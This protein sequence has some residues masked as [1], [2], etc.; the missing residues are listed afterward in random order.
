[1]EDQ[2]TDLERRLIALGYGKLEARYANY[3][4]KE[5]KRWL[6]ATWHQ[7]AVVREA[8]MLD[9][10]ITVLGT[11]RDA[12]G[13][14]DE[15]VGRLKRRLE[16]VWRAAEDAVQRRKRHHGR[17]KAQEPDVGETSPE[18]SQERRKARGA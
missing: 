12:S 16:E 4:R 18:V 14:L 3:V 1:M 17:S 13:S 9:F 10:A 8:D 2:R 15:T 11:L 7:P 6:T 5:L